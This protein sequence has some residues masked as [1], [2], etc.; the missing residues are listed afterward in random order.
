V[1][2]VHQAKID[3]AEQVIDEAPLLE[4]PVPMALH[5][6]VEGIIGVSRRWPVDLQRMREDPVAAARADE[7]LE[8][9]E[10]FIARALREGVLRADLPD[11]WAVDTLRALCDIAAHL[12]PDIAPGP[13]ADIVVDTLLRGLGPQ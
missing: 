8:R 2:A 7:L 4:A 9:L 12:Q 13:A 3:A 6:F 5:R 10:L 1:A 11:G